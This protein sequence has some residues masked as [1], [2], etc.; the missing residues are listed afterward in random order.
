MKRAT[1]AAILFAAGMSTADAASISRTYSYF[2]IGGTTLE[3]IETELSRRGPQ[4][5]GTGTRHPGATRME[6]TTRLGYGQGDGFCR[7]TQARVTVKADMILPRWR[8]RGRADTDTQLIWDTLS[9]D[10]KRHEESHV[11]IARTHASELE[12]ALL[13]IP[14]RKDCET[15]AARAKEITAEVLARHDAAQA[16]FDRIEGINFESRMLR[17]LRYRLEQMERG[18][19]PG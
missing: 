16:R 13:A 3:E 19:T 5:R 12:Q 18:R 11:V 10:I 6:F 9:S 4:L 15:V 14:R 17:L 7:I 8:Q 1:I 2:S